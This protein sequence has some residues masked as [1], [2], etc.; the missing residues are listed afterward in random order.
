MNFLLQRGRVFIVIFTVMSLA[1]ILF[2]TTATQNYLKFFPAVRGLQASISSITFRQSSSSHPE[3]SVSIRVI[4]SNDYSGITI[5]HVT[6]KLFFLS[7]NDSLFNSNHWIQD[8]TVNEPLGPRAHV[9]TNVTMTDSGQV[10][11]LTSFV[12]RYS[13]PVSAE[14]QLRVDF[15][16]FMGLATG[17]T[18]IQNEQNVP[19]SIS[20]PNAI[21]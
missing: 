19:L 5:G 18:V 20:P 13:G 4:N 21:L 7:L 3:V 15:I 11:Q 12:R 8:Q 1:S 17:P 10:S 16:T 2:I 6:V 9:T 14:I